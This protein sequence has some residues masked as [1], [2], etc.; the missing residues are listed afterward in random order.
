M[1]GADMIFEWHFAVV[2]GMGHGLEHIIFAFSNCN[3]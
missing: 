1:L 2:L 3:N